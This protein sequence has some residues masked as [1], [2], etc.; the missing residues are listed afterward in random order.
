[1]QRSTRTKYLLFLFSWEPE[2]KPHTTYFCSTQFCNAF[3]GCA[4]STH[5]DTQYGMISMKYEKNLKFVLE[6]VIASTTTNHGFYPS[7]IYSQTI[8]HILEQEF[9]SLGRLGSQGS[10]LI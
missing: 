7:S 5:W 10:K 1:M 4:A 9:F 8:G 3:Y 2:K 6:K